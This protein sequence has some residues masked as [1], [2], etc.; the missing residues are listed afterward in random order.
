MLSNIMARPQPPESITPACFRTSSSSGVRS[1]DCM[2]S[3]AACRT[4]V[5]MSAS[6]SSWAAS[7]AA[8]ADSRMMVSMVPSRGCGT[9]LYAKSVAAVSDAAKFWPVSSVSSC[10]PT[11]MPRNSWASMRPLLP[12]APSRAAR[13]ISSTVSANDD[14]RRASK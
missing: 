12:R 6:S 1:T 10:S 7:V 9:A 13:A 8:S 5:A 14:L 4:I 3:S 2:A 11:L